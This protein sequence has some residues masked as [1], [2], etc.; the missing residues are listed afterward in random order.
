MI[1]PATTGQT[2]YIP[3]AK[4]AKIFNKICTDYSI[5]THNQ[6]RIFYSFHMNCFLNKISIALNRREVKIGY[7]FVNFWNGTLSTI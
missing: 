2:Y 5:C 4:T 7:N 3:V 6:C 1:G